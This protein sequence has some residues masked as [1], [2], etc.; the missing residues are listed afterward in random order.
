MQGFKNGGVQVAEYLYDF[1][2]DGGAVG[3]IDLSAKKSKAPLPLG[4]VVVRITRKVL[5]APTSGGS[6]TISVGDAGS[7]ARYLALTAFDN[8]AFVA[9]VYAHSTGMPALLDAANKGQF[10]ISIAVAALTAG[11]IA[12]HVEY[13]LPSV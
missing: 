5:T 3:N 13:L 11:K 6:A 7:T 9:G 1:A 8:A 2:V 4:A 12:F 10:G